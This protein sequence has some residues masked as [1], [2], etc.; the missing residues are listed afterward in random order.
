MKIKINRQRRVYF[1]PSKHRPNAEERIGLQK[2]S[3]LLQQH[4]PLPVGP[5]LHFQRLMRAYAKGGPVAVQ[6]YVNIQ[7]LRFTNKNMN[8]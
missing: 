7:K 1:P 2:L 8:Q 4:V 6:H 5:R 3:E